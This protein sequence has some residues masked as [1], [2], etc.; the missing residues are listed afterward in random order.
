MRLD[1]RAES[2]QVVAREVLAKDDRVWVAD[3]DR[4][5]RQPLAR[6]VE[7][8]IRADGDL[9][10]FL[11]YEIV[12]ACCGRLH[13]STTGLDLHPV[14]IELAQQPGGC[15]PRAVPRHLRLGPVR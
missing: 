6:Q 15:D 1:R 13:E 5:H 7:L 14:R 4:N 9:P 11:P 3:V 12:M 8:L 10:E 2:Q